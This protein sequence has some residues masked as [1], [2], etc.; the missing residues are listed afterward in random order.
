[1]NT[2]KKN[3]FSQFM[4]MMDESERPMTSVKGL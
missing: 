4:M 2:P 3:E 1:M